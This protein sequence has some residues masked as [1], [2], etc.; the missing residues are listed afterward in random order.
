MIPLLQAPDTERRFPRF[1]ELGG[2][3]VSAY[4][5]FFCIGIY[6]GIMGSAALAVHSGISPL[7]MGAGCLV[8]AVAGLFGARIYHLII[9][10]PHYLQEKSWSAI[11]DSKRG[12][13]S[14]FRA[15]FPIVPLSFLV[16]STLRI[17]PAVFW[18]HMV[19]GIII[20]AI[21]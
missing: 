10:A 7:R 15:L 14:V 2:H 1:F 11:W 16:A 8:C 21:W 13:W 4:N 19:F 20:G 18:D 9:F 6:T 12:G 3:S 5:V 17:P